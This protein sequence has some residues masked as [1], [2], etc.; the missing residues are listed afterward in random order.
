MTSQSTGRQ[1]RLSTDDGGPEPGVGVVGGDSDPPR[2]SSSS[3]LKA[4]AST[5]NGPLPAFL[6]RRVKQDWCMDEPTAFPLAN[7][8]ELVVV[9]ASAGGVQAL[10]YPVSEL[11]AELVH[12]VRPSADLLFDS[13]A[14]SYKAGVIA[15]VLT[16]SGEDGATGVEAVKKMGGTVLAQ[17]EASSEF[18]GMPGSAI[19]TGAVDFVLPLD[20]IPG[21][22]VTLT[23]ADGAS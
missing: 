13:A 17:D 5:R 16:G 14:A 19:A 10:T 22:L 2:R 7:G 4:V 23:G 21:A 3:L 9:A 11:P 12:F 20:E 15:V 8:F 18:F 6:W 1:H